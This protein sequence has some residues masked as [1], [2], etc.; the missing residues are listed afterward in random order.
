MLLPH[1]LIASPPYNPKSAGVV[2]LHE[3]AST[4][5]SLGFKASIVI[6]TG[7]H[8]NYGW[9]I[10]SDSTLFGPDLKVTHLS[11]SDV[12]SVLE[13]GIVIYPEIVSGNPLGARRV[14]RYFLNR[15]GAVHGNSTGL[16]RD[17]FII[18]Y[19]RKFRRDAHEVLFRLVTSTHFHNR[20][21]RASMARTLDLTYCGKGERFAKVFT[22]PGSVRITN[23]WPQRKEELG[24]LLR[25]T[26]YLFSW[27]CVSSTNIDAIL[28]GAI[29]VFMQWSQASRD[30]LVSEEFGEFPY[31]EA[32]VDGGSVYVETNINRFLDKRREF[33]KRI[34]VLTNSW[35]GEVERVLA[36]MMRFFNCI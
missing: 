14:A 21:S 8:P 19:A 25:A 33:L 26:R 30:E 2:V 7:G 29:P 13:N 3:L 32:V 31:L 24:Q 18:A 9:G 23:L 11:P 20:S 27:D 22:V 34:E 35:E 15:E 16:T 1:I 6:M 4:I 5:V 17:E 10:A 36:S 28:C 12:S